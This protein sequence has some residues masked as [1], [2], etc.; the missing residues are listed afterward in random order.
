ML[1]VQAF[2]ARSAQAILTVMMGAIVMGYLV[3]LDRMTFS[4][5]HEVLAVLNPVIGWFSM[6]AECLFIGV[7]LTVLV[8]GFYEKSGQYHA[9][10]DTIRVIKTGHFKWIYT[11][12]VI[13]AIFNIIIIYLNLGYDPSTAQA[14]DPSVT[15]L[16]QPEAEAASN[17]GLAIGAMLLMIIKLYFSKYFGIRAFSSI[18]GSQKGFYSHCAID[19]KLINEG[20]GQVF[21][22]GAVPILAITMAIIVFMG[23][24]FFL[25]ALMPISTFWL[26]YIA[27][28]IR[29]SQGDRPKAKE[30]VTAQKPVFSC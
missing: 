13:F 6:V 10:N 27:A 4:L 9:W 18:I 15:G 3:Y 19:Q 24:K 30:K 16:S 11:L 7:F 8:T 23:M 12:A 14:Q 1:I 5:P 26:M 21:I 20:Y 28:A 29:H 2:K 22:Q 17:L 25:I